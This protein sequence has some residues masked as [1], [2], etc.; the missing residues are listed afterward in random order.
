MSAY[1]PLTEQEA[2]EIAAR[3]QEVFPPNA[4]LSSREIGDGNLNLVFHITDAVSGRSSTWKAKGS[5]FKMVP[6]SLV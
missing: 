2:I 5:A 1:H 6:F 4:T 3:I